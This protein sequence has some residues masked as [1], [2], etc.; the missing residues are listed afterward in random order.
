VDVKSQ[1][2][3]QRELT[4]ELNLKDKKELGHETLEGRL[5]RLRMITQ[6]R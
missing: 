2:M 3:I 1:A 6:R 4:F 5:H